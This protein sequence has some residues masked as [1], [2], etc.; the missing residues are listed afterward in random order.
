M[1]YGIPTPQYGM[2]PQ[3]PTSTY[4][5]MDPR[6][7]SGRYPG[8]G[9]P[10]VSSNMSNVTGY[11]GQVINLDFVT[12]NGPTGQNGSIVQQTPMV[13]SVAQPGMMH[14]VL[15]PG[16]FMP[17]EFAQNRPNNVGI[18]GHTMH[19]QPPPIHQ[20]QQP[21]P[22]V[23]HPT[24]PHL[25]QQQQQ[26]QQPS[27]SQHN[28][29]PQQQQQREMNNNMSNN[30]N[31]T[32]NPPMK[33]VEKSNNKQEVSNSNF[34]DELMGQMSETEKASLTSTKSAANKP[35]E[36]SIN[37][38]KPDE[39]KSQISE[40]TKQNE[41]I[42]LDE[43]KEKKVEVKDYALQICSPTEEKPKKKISEYTHSQPI[44]D[45]ALVIEDTPQEEIHS[46]NELK[47]ELKIEPKIQSKIEPKLEL[48]IIEPKK[49]ETESKYEL[50]IEPKQELDIEPKLELDII[51]PKK[52]ETESKY[53]LEIESNDNS[54]NILPIKNNV[55]DVEE[56]ENVVN[57]LKSKKLEDKR[58]SLEIDEIDS[59]ILKIVPE[60]IKK[61]IIDKVDDKVEEK[62]MMVEEEAKVEEKKIPR[63]P[64]MFTQLL[65]SQ[66]DKLSE[67]PIRKDKDT[68]EVFKY[69]IST[70]KEYSSSLNEEWESLFVKTRDE[71]AIILKNERSIDEFTFQFNSN[72]SRGSRML[73]RPSLNHRMNHRHQYGSRNSI[74]PKTQPPKCDW[75]QMSKEKDDL[76]Q[77]KTKTCEILN[78]ITP[79][80]YDVLSE[81]I[82]N[83]SDWTEDSHLA[84]FSEIIFVK[85]VDEPP[86][87]SM[88]IQILQ[89]LHNKN[90]KI[91]V[92]VCILCQKSF[93]KVT[94]ADD[95][96]YQKIK[97]LVEEETDE[98][99]KLR[100]ES[101]LLD[102]KAKFQERR[103]GTM[104][105]VG[106]L[107]REKLF[108]FKIF[109]ICARTL[110]ISDSDQLNCLCKILHEVGKYLDTNQDKDVANSMRNIYNLLRSYMSNKDIEPRVQYAIMD[111]LDRRKMGWKDDE[112]Q[113]A[114]PKPLD[115]L[116]QRDVNMSSNSLPNSNSFG[117]SHSHMNS[118]NLNHQ[119]SKP[120][121]KT[122]NPQSNNS[123]KFNMKDNSSRNS[124]R[125]NY[126]RDVG[127]TD[128]TSVRHPGR[129]RLSKD[130]MKASDS[131]KT[132]SFWHNRSTINTTT[133]LRPPQ[134][135]S[136]METTEKKILEPTT[137][138]LTAATA[139]VEKK[140]ENHLE[141]D[142]DD[143]GRVPFQ[144]D[145]TG[146]AKGIICEMTVGLSQDSL[147]DLKD[148]FDRT[149]R[150]DHHLLLAEFDKKLTMMM[151]EKIGYDFVV[152]CVK[153]LVND[154]TILSSSLT[155]ACVVVMKAF[156]DLMED[157][158]RLPEIYAKHMGNMSPVLNIKNIFT[159]I[160]ENCDEFL[161]K[162]MFKE[163]AKVES[164]YDFILTDDFKT[165]KIDPKLSDE[166]ITLVK[167]QNTKITSPTSKKAE[168]YEDLV[169][170]MKQGF[171]TSEELFNILERYKESIEHNKTIP[172]S[173]IFSLISVWIS[174]ENAN[175]IEK[176]KNV[177]KTTFPSTEDQ[178][179]ICDII[180]IDRKKNSRTQDEF[181]DT[182]EEFLKAE[183]ISTDSIID[184]YDNPSQNQTNP[185]L[186]RKEAKE[187]VM[188]IKNTSTSSTNDETELKE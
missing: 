24:H 75:A 170:A 53:E 175:C 119:Y 185:Y 121:R 22:S 14:P 64:D 37:S 169:K 50:K 148:T 67:E 184:W 177:V 158:P 134:F 41:K 87:Q 145:V 84:A 85:A 82:Q 105:F 86:F 98:T 133:N 23:H 47:I 89:K 63:D 1:Q 143:E 103:F 66:L 181:L 12:R 92:K 167:S 55:S 68:V 128:P 19:Q 126:N 88:Y 152:K 131:M 159:T 156:P 102:R 139:N 129:Q 32:Q 163:F 118:R 71:V 3:F 144:N 160:D 153:D 60:M 5:H 45:N 168:L 69:D 42:N 48:D 21:P 81:Q 83:L 107:T 187:F 115:E 173:L 183:L 11:G 140:N 146:Q 104:K 149:T 99:E 6:I 113:Q 179:Q 91:L 17:I 27:F 138:I 72:F 30:I 101:E 188:N 25:Q 90:P 10:M 33:I 132:Q 162:R 74:Q 176:F 78:K 59:N 150:K 95:E 65:N 80:K 7:V 40:Q 46:E 136:S 52:E 137:H 4:H 151:D 117:H 96:D 26:Q 100:L 111:L 58:K 165:F 9:Y 112:F 28:Q 44:V 97:K 106:G 141:D 93:E 73:N 130:K 123:R 16:Q 186:A 76:S 20:S 2:R 157:Y 127:I 34:F 51:E 77:L 178:R 180:E 108:L 109:E 154:K 57:I 124:Y 49:E 61:E 79:E 54:C 166:I 29:Q 18:N 36:I 110:L 182:L 155:E 38:T 120:N 142:D 125:Q 116:Q 15:V 174:T 172:K 56:D 164:F 62:V 43:S 31:S 114:K 39:K 122:I 161:K 147:L 35:K 94:V 8:V 135:S 13:S 70:L 171:C